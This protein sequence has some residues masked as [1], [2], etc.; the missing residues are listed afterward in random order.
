MEI[1]ISS[2]LLS[3]WRKPIKFGNSIPFV[4]N[5]YEVF[6][7]N[8]EQ[9]IQPFVPLQSSILS[10]PKFFGSNELFVIKDLNGTEKVLQL[11]SLPSTIPGTLS[12]DE[13]EN[14][15]LPSLWLLYNHQVWNSFRL[16]DPNF[17]TWQ[18]LPFRKPG[19][20]QIECL[21]TGKKYIGETQNIRQRIR[22]T[23][24]SLQRGNHA[25][26]ALQTDWNTFG[27]QNFIFKI[28]YLD[29][30]LDLKS[31]RKKI[32][33]FFVYENRTNVYNDV[34]KYAMNDQQSIEET[35]VLLEQFTKINKVLGWFNAGMTISK[36]Q[37]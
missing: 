9:S 7:C 31:L 37:L 25:S 17:Q 2:L 23:Y 36:T 24:N 13:S 3:T 5:L 1:F 28:L 18:M 15:N 22:N 16:S 12:Q 19:I 34:T 27:P 30:R 20:Y 6:G 14:Q 32:E 4:T 35:S 8:A 29:Q 10:N 21:Q 26:T 11:P 33:N